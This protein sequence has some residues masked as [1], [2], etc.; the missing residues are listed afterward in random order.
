MK[1]EANSGIIMSIT[2]EQKE[3]NHAILRSH[4]ELSIGLSQAKI[5]YNTQVNVLVRKNHAVRAQY[6]LTICHIELE[7]ISRREKENIQ[8]QAGIAKEQECIT[9]FP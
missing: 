6:G 5:D 3:K 4:F 1:Q 2:T 7:A 8:L 9:K